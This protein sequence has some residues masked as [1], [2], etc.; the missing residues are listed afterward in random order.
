MF[1]R[2]WGAKKCQKILLLQPTIRYPIFK[3]GCLSIFQDCDKMDLIY[4]NNYGACYRVYDV[5]NPKCI[6]QMV[7]DTVG[8]FMAK[9]DLKHLLTIVLQD[10]EPCNCD[11][12]GEE[13]CNRIWCPG[14]LLDFC[15]KVDPSVLKQ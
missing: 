15:L 2:G 12:C 11:E 14:P 5:P 10:P 3:T 4:R 9:D 6:L 1:L 8:I 13:G 7:I